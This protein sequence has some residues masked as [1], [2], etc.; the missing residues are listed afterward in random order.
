VT[1]YFII[2]PA[3]GEIVNAVETTSRE[4]A[5][6][7]A[8]DMIPHPMVVKTERELRP[9]VLSRYRYWSERP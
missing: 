4:R 5:Q 3:D 9:G 1:T 7:V 2:D 8:D 6:R